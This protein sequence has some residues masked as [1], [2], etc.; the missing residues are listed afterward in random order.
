MELNG[1]ELFAI[2]TPA[3]AALV[4]YGYYS[5]RNLLDTPGRRARRILHEAADLDPLKVGKFL[6]DKAYDEVP[7][8][9]DALNATNG[10]LNV[11]SAGHLH[12]KAEREN[13]KAVRTAK[14]VKEKADKGAVGNIKALRTVRNIVILTAGSGIAGCTMLN[15]MNR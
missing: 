1:P 5:I 6:K 14:I 7:R 10:F 3:A 4:A 13:R 11:C 12:R 15:L 9:S 2:A 8:T